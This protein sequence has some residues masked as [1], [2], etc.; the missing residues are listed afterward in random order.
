MTSEKLI[1][2]VKTMYYP[3]QLDKTYDGGCPCFWYK[4]VVEGKR[5]SIHGHCWRTTDNGIVDGCKCAYN[6]LHISGKLPENILT[7]IGKAFK[8]QLDLQ[9]W[10]S[11]W[12]L[13]IESSL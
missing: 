9:G 13:V 7:K 5:I 1:A 6:G 12:E 10:Y 11:D 4:P 8:K 3:Q 2:K